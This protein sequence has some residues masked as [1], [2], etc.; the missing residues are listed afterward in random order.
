MNIN[1]YANFRQIIG[2]KTVLGKSHPDSTKGL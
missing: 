1:F 2:G